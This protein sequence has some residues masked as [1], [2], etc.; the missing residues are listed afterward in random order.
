MEAKSRLIDHS[1]SAEGRMRLTFELEEKRDINDLIG[2]DVRLKADKWRNPRSL[3]ANRMMWACLGEL[4]AALRTSKDE[5]HDIMLRRYGTFTYMLIK[6][7]EGVLNAFRVI[8]EGVVEDRGTLYQDGLLMREILLV[9]PSRYYDTK[10]FSRLLEGIIDEM[11]QCGLET[12]EE[13][14]V[15]EA[16][17]EY[18]KVKPWQSQ[19]SKKKSTAGSADP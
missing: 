13:A 15:R 7:Q 8:W 18:E 19:S 17:E 3:Q 12:P 10:A 2:V 6:P 9:Y 4:A 11:H 16:L 1:F 5:M 14:R